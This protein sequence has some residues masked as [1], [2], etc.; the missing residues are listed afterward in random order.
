VDMGV[1]AARKLYI[2]CGGYGC[3]GGT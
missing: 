1:M 3:H 2:F